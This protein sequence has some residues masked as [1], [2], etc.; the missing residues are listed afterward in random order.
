MFR[1][2]KTIHAAKA[3]AGAVAMAIV[4]VGW[5]APVSAETFW[6]PRAGDSVVGHLQGAVATQEDTL[7][8]IGRRF[9]VGSPIRVWIRGFRATAP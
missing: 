9:N 2:R 8:D 1:I 5:L 4:C 6:L 3:A 7:L